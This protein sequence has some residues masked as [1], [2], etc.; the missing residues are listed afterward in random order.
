MTKKKKSLTPLS[1]LGA[2]FYSNWSMVAI[3]RGGH[4]ASSS[5]YK[6]M[7]GIIGAVSILRKI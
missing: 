4:S 3:H 6:Y 5:V 7:Y 2:L 1:H